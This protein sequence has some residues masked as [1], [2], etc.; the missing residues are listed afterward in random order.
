[1]CLGRIYCSSIDIP[2]WFRLCEGNILDGHDKNP[3]SLNSHR[4]PA[5][6]LIAKSKKPCYDRYGTIKISSCSNTESAKYISLDFTASYRQWWHLLMRENAWDGKQYIRLNCMSL[7]PSALPKNI[8]LIQHG[9][10]L[11]INLNDF[12]LS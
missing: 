10:L 3:S 5:N 11:N 7:I 2:H 8:K 6:A 4:C 9:A 1:M 12:S